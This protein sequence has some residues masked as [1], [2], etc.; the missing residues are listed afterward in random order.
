MLIQECARALW[1][2]RYE[3]SQRLYW[4]LGSSTILSHLIKLCANANRLQPLYLSFLFSKIPYLQHPK[5]IF[6]RILK[7]LGDLIEINID[8]RW[9]CCFFY[10]GSN[11]E[12]KVSVFFLFI[13]LLLSIDLQNH[14]RR[15]P[16]SRIRS[17]KKINCLF[18][19]EVYWRFACAQVGNIIFKKL[20]LWLRK[21]A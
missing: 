14:R 18:T 19:F 13:L 1:K 11:Q 16:T 8:R 10:V 20:I 17:E 5:Q 21:W 15:P 2:C 3:K 12:V 4:L 9:L 7:R 6:D